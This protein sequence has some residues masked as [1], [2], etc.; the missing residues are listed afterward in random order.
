MPSSSTLRVAGL[1]VVYYRAGDG[2][3]LVL[4]HGAAGD[5]REWRPQMAG[6]S[7]DFTVIAWDEPGAGRSSDVPAGLGLAGYATALGALID[8]VGAPAHVCGL[9][10][11]GTVALELY[12]RRPQ[13]VATLVLADTYAGWKGSLPEAEVRTRVRSVER[14][15]AGAAQTG[16]PSLP[17]L[18]AGEPPADA[19]EL[20]TAIAA[21][22]RRESVRVALAAMAEADLRDVLPHIAVPTL[23]IWGE[24]DA[25]SP[26]TVARQFASAIPDAELVLIPAAGHMSNLECPEAFNAAMRAF[27]ARLR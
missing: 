22:V 6:L 24:R 19:A 8:A 10:W 25:R 3:P 20:L 21:D 17:G 15:L 12:R 23:L 14:M 7:D 11:G 9:S 5:A 2:P 4:V 27:Y 26:L 16:R 1:D 13:A 18:F